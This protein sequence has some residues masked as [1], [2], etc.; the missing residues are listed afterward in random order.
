MTDDWQ[1]QLRRDLNQKSTQEL[2]QIW[3]Q[4]DRESWSDDAFDA[5]HELLTGRGETPPPQGPPLVKAG[6]AQP[7]RRERPGCVTAF[8]LLMG[9]A[10]AFYAVTSVLNVLATPGDSGML[11]GAAVAVAYAILY[12]VIA[13]GLWRMQN[14]ARIAAIVLQGI[15]MLVLVGLITSGMPLP[16][17]VGLLVGAY[18][19][20]WFVTN[21]RLFKAPSAPQAQVPAGPVE[22]PPPPLVEEGPDPGEGEQGG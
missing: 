11:V 16:A 15:G 2:L 1:I 17:I 9:F 5:I 21:G 13:V 8:A 4:N 18:S 22:E 14:W 3:S 10:A 7:D 6:I 19:I 12:L 20:Y